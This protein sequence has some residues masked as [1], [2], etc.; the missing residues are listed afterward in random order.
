MKS[1]ASHMIPPRDHTPDLHRSMLNRSPTRE[2]K[3]LSIDVGEPESIPL[4]A[5]LVASLSNQVCDMLFKTLILL[6]Y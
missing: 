2:C 1:I 6:N 3:T 4:S 5:W